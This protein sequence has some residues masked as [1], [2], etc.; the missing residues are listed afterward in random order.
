M[1]L[2]REEEIEFG[3]GLNILTGET[4]AGKSILIGSVNAALGEASFKDL[5]SEEADYSLAELVFE[6]DREEVLSRLREADLPLS[7]GQ[8]VI[9]RR[10]SGSRSISRIN[11]ETVPLSLVREIA[12]YLIDIHGQ[13]ANQAL[14][15]TASHLELVDS[16]AG[17]KASDL[18]TQCAQAHRRLTQ[19]E[20]SLA[21]DAADEQERLRRADFLT[22]EVKEIDAAALK[23]G[24]DEELE[25]K[26][27]RLSHA[28]KILDGLAEAAEYIDG[29]R[30]AAMQISRAARALSQIAEYDERLAQLYETISQ[31]DSLTGDFSLEL[32]GSV[33][34]FG[35]DGGELESVSERLNLVNRIRK[36]YGPEIADVLRSRDEKE[37]EL[38]RLQDYDNW[39]REKEKE[40]DGLAAE[41]SKLCGKLTA[42]RQESAQLLAEQIRRSLQDLNFLDVQF[43]IR[44]TPKGEM[45]AHGADD[46]TFMISMNPGMPLR[47]LHEVA[48]GGELSRIMLAIRTVMASRDETQSLIFDEIDAGISGRTAQRV[49]E[50]LAQLSCAHQVICITHLAQIAAMADRHFRIEKT[51]DDGMTHTHVR[52]LGRGEETE[53]LARILGG[54][55]I[56]DKVLSGAEEMKKLAEDYRAQLAQD[57]QA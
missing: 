19:A 48:S 22:F 46:V 53:E 16:F 36:R 38:E 54:A 56:T 13:H 39:R 37:A 21:E 41:L 9:S 25:E 7:D 55:Q 3:P 43:E 52:Q 17:K 28:Q 30:G 34:D 4:G 8:V 2:I 29:E 18:L 45:T 33:D 11:G 6:T 20:K 32:S 24:E 44:V 12:P 5:A 23:E 35:D 14:L 31:I 49:S 51:V 26:F 47:P 40:R 10:K 15:R 57:A 42:V 27:R 50:K 1:A